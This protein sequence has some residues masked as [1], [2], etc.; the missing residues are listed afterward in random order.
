MCHAVHNESLNR[1]AAEARETDGMPPVGHTPGP[2]QL[3]L[4]N[5]PDEI[6][7]HNY[8]L[9]TNGYEFGK[10]NDE[11]LSAGFDSSTPAANARLIAAA[12]ELLEACQQLVYVLARLPIGDPLISDAHTACKKARATIAQATGN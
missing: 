2:W 3:E 6:G 12:P 10:Y 7:D 1:S 4:N 9:F 5:H 8:S 11:S